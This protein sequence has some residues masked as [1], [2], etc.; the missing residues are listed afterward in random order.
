MTR[1]TDNRDP[2]PRS[3]PVF[4]FHQPET[5]PKWLKQSK[6]LR[7]RLLDLPELDTT[8]LRDCQ[9]RAIQNLERSFKDN[10]PR[11]L[12]QMA[13]GSGKT[14]TAVISFKFPASSM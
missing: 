10:R 9:T 14:F 1:F 6:S 3:R 4:S 8:G 7:A 13:T 11:A 5:P 2:K 12:I